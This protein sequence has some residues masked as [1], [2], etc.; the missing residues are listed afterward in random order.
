[1]TSF[2]ALNCDFEVTRNGKSFNFIGR[3]AQEILDNNTEGYDS[4]Y[5]LYHIKISDVDLSNYNYKMCMLYIS[6]YEAETKY[7]REIVI[8]ENV[9]QKI[10][11]KENIKKIRFLYPHSDLDKD[12]V[13]HVNVID[14]ALYKINIF[15]N[16][17]N[18]KEE[19]ISNTQILYLNS[20]II[21]D[22]CYQNTLCPIIVEIIYDQQIIKEDP[23][24]E[25]STDLSTKR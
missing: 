23:M 24:L 12:V 3:Y 8:A 10:I 1:M 20:E 21:T 4:E 13:V 7:D 17:N 5:Y 2:L 16:G 9:N 6:G 11:F 18:T 19:K 22:I 15:V 14:K 25:I